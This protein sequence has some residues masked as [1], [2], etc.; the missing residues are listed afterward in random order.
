MTDTVG[1]AKPKGPRCYC[2]SVMVLRQS[3]HIKVK[4]GKKKN[5]WS[6]IRWP[7]C[8]GTIG[9][10]PGGTAPLGIPVN[11]ETRQLRIKAHDAFDAL[12]QPMGSQSKEYRSAAYRW[13]ADEM[14]VFD[15][16]IGLMDI[17]HLEYVIE[18]CENM[19]PED[20]EDFL[21]EE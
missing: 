12:W 8:D 7:D 5:F 1:F 9:C 17:E 10:H 6:C 21:D 16:H 14:E 15:P 19:G 11:K 2:G 13:L 18:V 4:G 3:R 20:I